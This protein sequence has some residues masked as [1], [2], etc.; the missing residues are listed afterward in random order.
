MS[1]H[2][3]GQYVICGGADQ[4]WQAT[5]AKTLCGAKAVASKTYQQ[6]AGRKI[7]VAQVMQKQYV[8]VA[9]KYGYDKWG[10]A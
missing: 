10:A 3:E 9:I 8:R 4:Y 6:A 2:Q 1:K 5:S 7:E